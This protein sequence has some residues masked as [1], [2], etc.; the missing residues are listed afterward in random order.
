[1]YL[2]N[3]ELNVIL[4][5]MEFSVTSQDYPFDPENQ[6]QLC[7]IDL[8]ISNIFWRQKKVYRHI[9]LG[10]KEEHEFFPRGEW[11][12]IEINFDE[13]ITLKPGE[14]LLGRTFESFKIPKN[15]AGKIV[16]KSSFARLGISVFCS[17]DFIN[18]GWYGHCPMI[19][20]NHGNHTFKI[21]PLLHMCQ[22]IVTDLSSLPEGEFGIGKF[23]SNYQ[24]DDGGPSFWW[25]DQ[26]FK[27]IRSDYRN[28]NE[29]TLNEL[30]NSVKGID[31]EGL[32]RFKFFLTSYEHRSSG[33]S[34][35]ILSAFAKSEKAKKKKQNLLKGILGVIQAGLFGLS[36]KLF[37]ENTYHQSYFFLWIFTGITL[38]FS[39]WY[40]SGRD[41]KNYYVDIQK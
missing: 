33:N 21:H 40:I 12:R 1:M 39:L 20:K 15:Y 27:A 37:F 10:K 2:S 9:D 32:S 23:V 36:L 31:D 22:V 14:L 28:I 11:K 41:E 35:D 16:A 18:P 26:V 5:D 38:T 17:T 24:N 13:T 34:N 30:I 25:R 4:P 8:R 29:K 6:V 3:N 7:S 19:I